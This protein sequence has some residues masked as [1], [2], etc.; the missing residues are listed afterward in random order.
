MKPPNMTPPKR[1]GTLTM[2]GVL[3][4]LLIVAWAVHY[5]GFFR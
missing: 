5:V 1:P 3:I 4:F 2:F